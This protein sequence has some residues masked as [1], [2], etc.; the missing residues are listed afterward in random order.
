MLDDISDIK[1]KFYKKV[2]STVLG[3]MLAIANND[4]LY[5]LEFTNRINLSKS[6]HSFLRYNNLDSI[7]DIPDSSNKIL[8]K[9]NQELDLYFKGKLERFSI[10]LELQGTK[11]QI[12]AWQAL[13]KIPF[14]NIISYASQAKM[15]NKPTAFRAVANANS[16]NKLSIIVP[17]HRVIA[18]NGALGG[19]AGGIERKEYLLDLELKC[20][21][22]SKFYYFSGVITPQLVSY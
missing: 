10:P 1:V 3:D 8:A 5:L 19:Y 15:L 17:C 7:N 12:K 2:F 9:V 6:I 18:T 4:A 11:F 20:I 16:L 14:G 21:K 22:Y 13:L